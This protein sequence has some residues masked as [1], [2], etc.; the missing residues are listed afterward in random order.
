MYN[1]GMR[2]TLPQSSTPGTLHSSSTPTSGT[3]TLITGMFSS[4]LSRHR[5]KGGTLFSR[6]SFGPSGSGLGARRTRN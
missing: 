3:L 4:G 2:V 6:Q 5:E 1:F